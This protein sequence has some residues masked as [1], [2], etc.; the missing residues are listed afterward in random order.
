[1]ITV[2]IFILI[3]IIALISLVYSFFDT[4]NPIYANIFASGIS[5]VL[6]LAMAIAISSGNV[7]ADTMVT[8][9]INQTVLNTSTDLNIT[10]ITLIEN[11]I[12][13]TQIIDQSLAWIYVILTLIS[14]I[15]CIFS[16]IRRIFTLE[17][18]TYEEYIEVED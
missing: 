6:F 14:T 1:M 10:S 8:G 3:S 13:P 5:V 4:D 9:T 17:E 15:T 12:K 16:I 2:S 18:D 7:V 11:H